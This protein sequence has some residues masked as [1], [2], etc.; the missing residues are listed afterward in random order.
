MNIVV[1]GKVIPA[2]SVTIEIDP[3]TKRMA[4]KGVTHELDPAAASAVEEGLRLTEKHGGT[5]TLVTMGISDATIGIRNAL[6]MGATSAVHV[7]DDAVAGSDTLGTAKV[8]AAAIKKLPFDLVIC[9]TESSDSYSGIVPGQ[10]AHLLG[11][12]PVTFAR[13]I[14]LDGNRI[15][16]KRQSEGGYD[17]VEAALPVVVTTTSGIN[18]PRYPQLKGIMAAKKKEI[19]IYTAA[20]LGLSADQVGEAGAKEKVLTVGRPPKRQAGKVVVD[21]GE[22][23]KQIADFL[24]ELKII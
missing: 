10:V 3:A 12:P 2:S 13:E 16:I 4:R 17:V 21:E 1:C 6:A 11:I 7:L 18:E 15:T 5:V 23:G 20:E 9:A 22:G 19:K 8:L 24:A 14:T